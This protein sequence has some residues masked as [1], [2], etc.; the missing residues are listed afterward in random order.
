M[1]KALWSADTAAPWKEVQQSAADTVQQHAS[2][3]LQELNRYA[4]EY[5]AP[6]KV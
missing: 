6:R 5:T 2:E 3:K 1:A 4:A